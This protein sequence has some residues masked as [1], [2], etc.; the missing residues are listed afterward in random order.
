MK[1]SRRMLQ[2]VL[3][4]VGGMSLSASGVNFPVGTYIYAGSVLDYRH[5]V[6]TANA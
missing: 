2:A 3:A 4:L 5:E 1:K 6:V